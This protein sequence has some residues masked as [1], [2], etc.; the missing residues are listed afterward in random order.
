MS[1]EYLDLMVATAR[2][3]G[4][5]A[6][7]YFVKADTLDVQFKGQADLLCAADEEVETLIRQQLRSAH[8][9][10]A[11]WGEESGRSG[12]E[13]AA[14]SWVVDPIDGTTNF[15]SGLPFTISIALARGDTP[16]AGV[17]YTPTMDEMFAAAL[18]AGATLNAAPITVRHEVDPARFVV[19]TG[20]PLD[21]HAYSDGA[22]DRLFRL[23]EMVS[24]VRIMGSCALSL[25]HVACGRLDGYFEGPTGFLDC[26]AG[27]VILREA[28][29]VVTD[30]WGTE[31]FPLNIT[32]TTG[33]PA[34]H[35]ALLNIT[36]TAP[37]TPA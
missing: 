23:R 9:E 29:G 24:A 30:F 13:G 27:I 37:R 18:G 36:R 17:I 10:I 22:Y 4:V 15:L 26:A 21:Q 28:G 7:E 5:L 25:A 2:A 19:G 16:L 35:A 20:L 3:A 12:P 14:L 6:M 32:H 33:A 34:C 8:P 1:A 31:D 11:F